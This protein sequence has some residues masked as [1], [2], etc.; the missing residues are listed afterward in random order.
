MDIFKEVNENLKELFKNSRPYDES[1]RA[2]SGSGSASTS[3]SGV[4]DPCELGDGTPV[5]VS[6]ACNSLAKVEGNGSYTQQHGP[7]FSQAAGRYQFVGSTAVEQIIK[8][9]KAS[10]TAQAREIWTRCRTSN[11]PGCKVL[12]DEM[13]NQYSK[14]LM[15]SLENYGIPVTN[16][17]LYL[18]WNQGVGGAKVI[19][20]AAKNNTN[21]TNPE[22]ASNMTNQAWVK[23]THAVTFLRGMEGFMRTRGVDP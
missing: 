4:F 19:L 3:G 13:C 2:A 11:S 14:S 5:E 12:Q 6:E 8:L 20:E 9:G 15:K 7:D 17:N 21:V 23:S 22:V 1:L 10:N 18:A 16:R